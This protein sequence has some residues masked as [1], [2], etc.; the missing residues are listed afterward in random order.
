MIKNIRQLD[1][2]IPIILSSNNKDSFLQ[3]I[4]LGISSYITKPINTTK[5]YED[6]KRIAQNLYFKNQFYKK[7]KE[8]ETYT[9]I[10]EKV[11]VISK[12]D[13]KGIITYV[14]D[15]FCEA[16]GY[17]RDELIGQNHNIVRHPDNPKEVYKN[18]W[19]TI[20]KGEIWEA[21]VRNIDKEGNTWYAKSNF[22]PIFDKKKKI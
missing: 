10:I 21:R 2:D 22:F 1:N 19:D 9:N 3:S 14:D 17:T 6:I 5:L 18:L 4:E 8:L 16:S 13:L 7:Q 11:A 15:A 20:Q 12:T